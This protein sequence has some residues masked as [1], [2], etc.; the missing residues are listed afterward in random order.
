MNDW[1]EE[2]MK[3]AFSAKAISWDNF[4]K[5]K[6]DGYATV[7]GFGIQKYKKKG[8]IREDYVFHFKELGGVK[9]WPAGGA[10]CDRL[11]PYLLKKFGDVAGVDAALKANPMYWKLHP[12]GTTK[13][14]NPVR[15]YEMFKE[16][17]ADFGGDEPK[18]ESGDAVDEEVP[19]M[20]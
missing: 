18:E 1:Q 5:Q 8:Q 19:D 11:I 6:P 15:I 2:A 9:F 12:M 13:E 17:P 20:R 16:P 7:D 10:M 3:F 4:L 14:G